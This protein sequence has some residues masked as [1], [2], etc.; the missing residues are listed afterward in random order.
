MFVVKFLEAEIWYDASTH[1]QM[2]DAEAQLD[3][4]VADEKEIV[5]EADDYVPTFK[6]A[7]I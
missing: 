3:R 5:E 2:V 6:P 1:T 7:V 4:I